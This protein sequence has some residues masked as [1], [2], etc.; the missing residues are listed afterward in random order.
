MIHLLVGNIGSGK[1]TFVRDFVDKKVLVVND[2][3]IVDA[4]HG[5]I[6]RLYQEENKPLYKSIE[7]MIIAW[8]VDKDYDILIDRP[9]MTKKSR[10]RYIGIAHSLDV[11]IKA[12]VFP[13][14]KSTVH[15]MRRFNS[16]PRGY[17][18]ASWLEVAERNREAY[19]VPTVEEGLFEVEFL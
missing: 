17:S 14:D 5:G 3:A 6:N 19:E 7:N 18:Y 13:L 2:D 1:S 4:C 15:A 9:N 12:V 11:S 8:G 10:K 16:D